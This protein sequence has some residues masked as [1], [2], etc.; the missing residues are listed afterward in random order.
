MARTAL[1]QSIVRVM[2]RLVVREQER[3]GG[4]SRRSF[5]A[6]A[7]GTVALAACG[8]RYTTASPFADL[9]P[10]VIVGGGTA[11]LVCAHRLVQGGARVA[12]FE[13]SSRPGGR[14]FSD[15]RTFGPL[16][17]E[18]GGEFIDSGHVR[19]RALAQELGLTLD[20]L[21]NTTAGLAESFHFDGATRSS[22]EVIA[23]LE[24]I[25]SAV[26]ESLATIEKDVES[27]RMPYEWG[28]S[29]KRLDA[30][31]IDAWLKR[32]D[33][34]GR[35]DSSPR[36]GLGAAI[37][38]VAYTTELGLEPGELSVIPMLQ[39]FRMES[40]K[41]QMY[42]ESDERFHIRGGNDQVP[43]RLAQRLAGAVRY[44][45]RLNAIRRTDGGKIALVFEG[46]PAPVVAERVVLALPFSVLRQVEIDP[47]LNWSARK[48]KSI[49]EL[50]YGTNAK[51]MLGFRSRFWRS[52]GASGEV[53][54]DLRLQSTWDTTRAQPSQRGILTVFKGGNL[55]RD[56]KNA[57]TQQAMDD[58]ELVFPGAAASADQASASFHWPT[59][60]LSLGSYSTWK[61]GQLTSFGGTEAE[62]E[63]AVHFAGEHTSL[64][65]QG[66]ME[67]AVESGERAAREILM[68]LERDRTRAPAQP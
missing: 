18:L 35:A 20:D 38:R 2:G 13:A 26:I 55:G 22:S 53:F 43:G 24:P 7:A 67:G 62:P 21:Q 39:M 36:A 59:S 64:S 41:L 52:R 57:P 17:C 63:G 32:L 47:S 54:T 68:A 56:L 5:L 15:R 60:P 4:I 16:C 3:T 33:E 27:D 23:A 29:A 10:V 61:V 49:H 9:P 48:L 12:V 40:Q 46:L 51:L 45:A 14:M 65:A 11:G 28:E 44:R 50:G 42:G 58:L 6:G 30:T 19:I 66:Y 8:G 31:S 34:A 1:L 37:L 25:A